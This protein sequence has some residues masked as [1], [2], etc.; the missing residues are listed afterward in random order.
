M[1]RRRRFDLRRPVCD[2][3]LDG[4]C[5]ENVVITAISGP[6]M[7]RLAALGLLG[8]RRRGWAETVSGLRKNDPRTRHPGRCRITLLPS[9]LGRVPITAI[10][11]WGSTRPIFPTYCGA[12]GAGSNTAFAGGENIRF[13]W[14]CYSTETRQIRRPE[15]HTA[16]ASRR[17]SSGF[18]DTCS[19]SIL[20]ARVERSWL[21][22]ATKRERSDWAIPDMLMSKVRQ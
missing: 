6:S 4:Y 7:L 10:P 12:R 15:R 3:R 1:L 16:L 22:C 2:L 5:V 21:T 14:P 18:A 11:G 20:L 9:N 8:L 17:P 13:N 19:G